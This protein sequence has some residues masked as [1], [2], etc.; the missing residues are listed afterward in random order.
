MDP[1]ILPPGPWTVTLLEQRPRFLR[2]GPPGEAPMAR[3]WLA[4][5]ASVVLLVSAVA[6][7]ILFP[8]RLSA[9]SSGG[10]LLAAGLLIGATAFR[11]VEGHPVVEV[12]LERLRIQ[13]RGA[14]PSTLLVSEALLWVHP[15]QEPAAATTR[16]TVYQRRSWWLSIFIEESPATGPVTLHLVGTGFRQDIEFA[17]LW[18]E[19]QAPWKG[20]IVD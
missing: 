13:V 9:V 14:R 4:L 1:L 17:A 7:A 2:F 3:R 8:D 5:G 10:C 15:R 16:E 20:L 12:D 18:L 11:R 19:P 6:A